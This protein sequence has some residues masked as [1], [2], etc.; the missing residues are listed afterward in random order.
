MIEAVGDGNIVRL[1]IGGL[2]L[3]LQITSHKLAGKLRQRY[4]YYPPSAEIRFTAQVEISSEGPAASLLNTPIEFDDR[5]LRCDVPGSRGY[6][7]PVQRR[8][9]LHLNTAQPLEEVDYFLRMV[10]SL[11]AFEAGGLLFH[12]A[13]IL[14]RGRAYLFFGYSGSGKTTVARLSAK[15]EVINDD[16]VLLMPSTYGWQVH[17]TPFWNH[18]QTQL[19]TPPVELV[20]MFRLVQDSRVYLESASRAHAVAEMVG[21][22][23]VVSADTDRSLELLQRCQSI[24]DTVPVYRLHFLKDASF[25]QVIEEAVRAED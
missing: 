23:P 14:R 4:R 5:V 7:D 10:C 1:D 8:G 16:L 20:G 13:G 9:D 21:S 22:I 15:D 12:A 25:W 2:G 24:L 19:P 11:L 6:I 17:A 18:Y 3:D